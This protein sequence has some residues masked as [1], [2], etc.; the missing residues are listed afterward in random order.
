M[1][2]TAVFRM[3]VSNASMKKATDT[4]HGSSRL[5][6]SPAVLPVCAC[7]AVSR[8]LSAC[9]RRID[10]ELRFHDQ[11]AQVGCVVKTFGVNLVNILGPRLTSGEPTAARDDLD[12]AEGCVVTRS[13]SQNLIDRIAGEF[14]DP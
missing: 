12:P 10:G 9:E 7:K 1:A 6:V 11:S 8:A 2:G 4:N 3:V 5:D 14:R 13:V